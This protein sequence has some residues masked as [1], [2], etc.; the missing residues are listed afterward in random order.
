VTDPV[1]LPPGVGRLTDLGNAHR[2]AALRGDSLRYAPGAGWLA[3][4]EPAG[5]A[6]A[7]D[8]AAAW[9]AGEAAVRAF[10]LECE[11]E[12]QARSTKMRAVRKAGLAPEH[13]DHV[14]AKERLD[15]ANAALAFARKSQKGPQVRAMLDCLAMF[16]EVRIEPTAL[17][18]RPH[19]LA[20]PGSTIDLRDGSARAPDRLDLLSR[21]TPVPYLPDDPTVQKDAEEW[22]AW[23]RD[24]IRDDETVEHL[25]VSCGYCATGTAQEE[26]FWCLHGPPGNGKSTLVEA[27]AAAL[28]P[29][30]STSLNPDIFVEKRGATQKPWSLG[31][32]PG[33]RLATFSEADG[34]RLSAG[35]L[36]RVTGY[37]RLEAEE[38]YKPSFEY[39]PDWKLMFSTN[40]LPHANPDASRNGLWRRLAL[41]PCLRPGCGEDDADSRVKARWT[42]P[43]GGARG[44]LLWVVRAA[45]RYHELGRLPPR[46]EAMRLAT[47]SYRRAC[48]PLGR[49]LDERY[50]VATPDPEG[51]AAHHVDRDELYRAFVEWCARQGERWPPSGA[52]VRQRLAEPPWRVDCVSSRRGCGRAYRGLRP[53][54]AQDAD[55]PADRA[56]PDGDAPDE[57]PRPSRRTAARDGAH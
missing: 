27:L 5:P 35:L 46:S 12:A 37:E 56:P 45:A 15:T 29:K 17:D 39:R 54:D 8:E 49:F 42:D 19:L 16:E 7:R 18:A 36:C 47:E 32:L 43:A 11:A 38:K 25:R 22:G 4:P 23:V 51:G 20:A 33:M 24:L 6:W 53:L 14:A 57:P 34:Q 30:L 40:G 10:L 28:G 55:D 13:D 21:A 50:A 3:W 9:R 31:R 2:L 41:V 26:K 44:V 52:E 48:D 1:H